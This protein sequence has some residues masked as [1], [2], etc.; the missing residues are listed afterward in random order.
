LFYKAI[1]NYNVIAIFWGHSHLSQFISWKGINTWCVGSGQQDP[2][3]G[4]FFVVN[5]NPKE[6][7]VAERKKDGWGL[8]MKSAINNAL[9]RTGEKTP[10]LIRIASYCFQHSNLTD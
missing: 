6:M 1:K 4:Q 3:P 8:V 2:E 9:H 10:E 7:I 5:I